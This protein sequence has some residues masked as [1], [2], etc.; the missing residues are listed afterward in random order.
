M[1]YMC[2]LSPCAQPFSPVV[3]TQTPAQTG[4]SS[5]MRQQHTA[6]GSIAVAGVNDTVI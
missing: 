3:M 4:A 2:C 6:A 1:L 5:A